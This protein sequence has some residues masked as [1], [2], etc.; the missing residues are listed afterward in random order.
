MAVYCIGDIQGCNDELQ[1]LLRRLAFDPGRDRLW[2]T[3]D[4]VNRG[5]GSLE[6]LR[7]VKSLGDQASIVLGNHDIHLLAV[8]TGAARANPNDT[9][10]QI[11]EAPD[12]DT[13]LHWLRTQPLMQE[14][15][16]LG[17]VMLHAGLYPGWGLDQAR[18]YARE[19]E[20][21]LSGEH[22]PE[23]FRHMYGS[24]PS[25]WSEALSGWDRLRFIIN[26]FTRMRY[27]DERGRLL[28]DFKGAP[29]E[30]PAG[31]LPWFQVPDRAPIPSDVTLITGHWSTLGYHEEPGLVAI[32][33]GCLWGG[34]LTAIRLDGPRE[35]ISIACK[36]T[37]NPGVD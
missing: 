28:L 19:A 13:L 8:W 3:G 34:E 22:Y 10:H 20:L 23:L 30:R 35:R 24:E 5:P 7:F 2:L 32:D 11:L 6:V 16:T 4:L 33:T 36:A 27:C 1:A 15:H 12:A 29:G 37:A 17:Y 21:A 14:D 18:A 25:R 26:A 31:H 9:L